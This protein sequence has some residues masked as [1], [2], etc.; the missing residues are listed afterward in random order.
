MSPPRIG[1]TTGLNGD[2]LTLDLAYARA[3]EAAGCIAIVLPI[4]ATARQA[5]AY[6]D[7]LDGLLMTGG[8][9]ITRGL[10]GALPADLPPVD[11]RRDLS[12]A[13]IYAAMTSKPFLGICY[14]MQF[15]NALAGGSIYADAQAQCAVPAHSGERGGTP[16]EIAI[17]SGS[18]LRQ[19]MGRGRLLANTHHIQAIAELG[20]GLS[21]SA[22]SGDGLIEAIESADGRI[23][24]TQFHPE[25]MSERGQP[26]F[27]D[28]ARRARAAR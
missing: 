19:I 20:A 18:H 13:L 16:H 21:V 11:P 23:I 6:A 1:I 17:A 25:R 3:L 12:D 26:L 2:R 9:G 27:D 7:M 5:Q 10:I 8:P 4:M 14:G 24:G 22:R 28:L 15:A